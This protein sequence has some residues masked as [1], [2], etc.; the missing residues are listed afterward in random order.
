MMKAAV[1]TV[2]TRAYKAKQETAAG[3]AVKRAVEQS[4]FTVK[5]GVLPEDKTVVEAVLRQLAD[6]GSVHLIL[7]VGSTG[8]LK[9]NCAPDALVDAAERLLPGIPEAIRAYNIRY[10][11][12]VILDRSA[13]GI[14]NRTVMVNLPDAMELAKEGIEYILPEL[15]Q[16]VEM[17][18][19]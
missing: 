10:S 16:A 3:A 17:L 11:K 13:A 1:F 18:N 12:K 5:A 19:V 14:R 6:T 2:S 4:G 9:K 7:T 15:M 8:L